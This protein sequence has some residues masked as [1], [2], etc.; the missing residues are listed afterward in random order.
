MDNTRNFLN[1]PANLD[2]SVVSGNKT[3]LSRRA[4][5]RYLTVG[6]AAVAVQGCGG[7]GAAAAPGQNPPVATT[8]PPT[9][10]VPTTPAPIPTPGAPVWLDVPPITFTQGIASSI[11]VSGYISVADAKAVTVSLN[12]SP[13]PAGVTF[14]AANRSFDYDGKGAVDAT[15]GHVLI[16]TVG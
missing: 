1:T 8:P 5:M 9:P 4:F 7:G 13:L 12:A 15:D 2:S 16:A 3:A 11:S 14:N 10:T 6:T